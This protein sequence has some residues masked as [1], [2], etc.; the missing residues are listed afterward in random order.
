MD[1]LNKLDDGWKSFRNKVLNDDSPKAVPMPSTLKAMYSRAC[2]F[3]ARSSPPSITANRRGTPKSQQEPA[4]APIK[5]GRRQ[6][7][8]LRVEAEELDRVA[9]DPATMESKERAGEP[10]Q[11]R[12]GEPSRVRAAICHVLR[13]EAVT[14]AAR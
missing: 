1:F 9:L 5:R 14:N 10:P 6:I 11:T 7:A 8:E 4:E 12:A 2:T 3:Q 13:P